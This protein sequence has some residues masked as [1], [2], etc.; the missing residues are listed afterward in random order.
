MRPA[1]LESAHKGLPDAE[2]A[3]RV[4]AG[5]EDA[6]RLLMRRYNQT[7][8]RTARSILKDDA[9]AEDAVQEAYLRA[10]RAIGPGSVTGR[11]AYFMRPSSAR[12]CPNP[13][14]W[15]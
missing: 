15:R 4:A 1:A 8:Y 11:V 14:H 13:G 7:L 2:I 10:Y 9:E 6:L 5:D 3:R 12:A